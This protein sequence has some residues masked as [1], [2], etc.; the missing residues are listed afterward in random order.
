MNVNVG[1]IFSVLRRLPEDHDGDLQASI[2]QPGYTQVA[3]GYVVY[4]PS[5]VLVY[6]TGNGVHGFT[7]DPTI[8][9][10]VLTTEHMKMPAQGKYYSV[11]EANSAKWPDEYREYVDKLRSGA[12]Q[13][14]LRTWIAFPRTLTT[15]KPSPGSTSATGNPSSSI[16]ASRIASTLSPGLYFSSESIVNTRDDSRV[17]RGNSTCLIICLPAATATLF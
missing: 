8:G 7:L 14:H 4:G 13:P 11:N 2:L 16:T 15:V 12:Y 3:A 1:T 5:T 10:F 9:A 17:A 6:T